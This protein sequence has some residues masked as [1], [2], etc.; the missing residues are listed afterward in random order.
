MAIPR[1]EID[2]VYFDY[3]AAGRRR[4]REHEAREAAKNA[5]GPGRTSGNLMKCG[6]DE[7]C[8]RHLDIALKAVQIDL[9]EF[10]P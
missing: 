2:A 9:E 10:A 8:G 6:I 3:L 5:C 1:N 4:Q 7:V